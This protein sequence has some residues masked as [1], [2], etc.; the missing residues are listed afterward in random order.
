MSS[1]Y[2]KLGRQYGKS[3]VALEY[4]KLIGERGE[5]SMKYYLTQ[6]Q[7]KYFL[8]ELGQDFVDN[9]CVLVEG[10]IPHE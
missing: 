9:C 7:Y 6:S 10:E 4:I 3:Q 8:D 2:V 1:F 5:P